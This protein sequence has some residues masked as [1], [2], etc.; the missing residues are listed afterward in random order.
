MKSVH[1]VYYCAKF[2][3]IILSYGSHLMVSQK[4]W[5]ICNENIT[6]HAIYEGN[7]KDHEHERFWSLDEFIISILGIIVV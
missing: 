4:C 2:V 3:V 6:H 7:K 1:L 5:D